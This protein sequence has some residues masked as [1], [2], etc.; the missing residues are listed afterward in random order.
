MVVMQTNEQAI[1]VARRIATG[2][3]R[4][5][6]VLF[7]T[8]ELT[9]PPPLLALRNLTIAALPNIMQ[10]LH[11]S[12]PASGLATDLYENEQQNAR[13]TRNH[14]QWWP[15]W[16]LPALD[17]AARAE[18]LALLDALAQR[19]LPAADTPTGTHRPPA[20]ASGRGGVAV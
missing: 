15:L 3:R 19:L 4:L 18:V 16:E 9:V 8:E 17:T 5:P 12:V 11:G 13:E 6:T 20:A 10:A 2:F 1:G 7:V 14:T